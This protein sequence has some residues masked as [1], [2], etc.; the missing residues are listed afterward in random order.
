[1]P[2]KASP[3]ELLQS[4]KHRTIDVNYDMDAAADAGGGD[5]DDYDNYCICI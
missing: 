4:M 3:A 2:T 1:M 5:D